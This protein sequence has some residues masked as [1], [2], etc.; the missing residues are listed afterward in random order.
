M[1]YN[2]IRFLN[3]KLIHSHAV[4]VIDDLSH[5]FSYRPSL[6]FISSYIKEHQNYG[7]LLTVYDCLE[8]LGFKVSAYICEFDQIKNLN[9]IFIAQLKSNNAPFFSIIQDEGGS[10]IYKTSEGKR[11]IASN[12]DFQEIWTGN[13][14]DVESLEVPQKSRSLDLKLASR[15]KTTTSILAVSLLIYLIIKNLLSIE[16]NRGFPMLLLLLMLL[17]IFGLTIASLLLWNEIDNRSNIVQSI[18]SAFGKSGCNAVTDSLIAK[19]FEKI[20]SFNEIGFI[21]FLGTFVYLLLDVNNGSNLKFLSYLSCSSSFFI[22]FSFLYQRFV[23]KNWCVLCVLIQITLLSEIIVFLS[24]GGTNILQYPIN[25]YN[26]VKLAFIFT[27]LAA[28]IKLIKPHLI[29]SKSLISV[30]RRLNKIK[31]D[32]NTFSSLMSTSRQ[33]QKPDEHLGI[34]K[35]SKSKIELIKVCS[36]YCSPCSKVHP[37]LDELVKNNLVNL[38]VIF[39]A[40]PDDTTAE[41]QVVAH[42]MAIY[43]HNNE[44][45][46]EAMDLWYMTKDYKL[47]ANKFP[48]E[49]EIIKK[50]KNKVVDMREWCTK[51]EITH[52]PTLFLNNF[53]LP[54]IY[55]A[56]DLQVLL[57]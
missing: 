43:A 40:K 35:K 42:L 13:V 10:Y 37:I 50:Q 12:K 26:V 5:H 16:E 20:L 27:A 2:P 6:S 9:N 45:I 11:I 46:N 21:Y 8:E 22:A 57:S 53:L 49:D 24:F 1:S 36:P 52:T 48:I 30:K 17:K 7:S 3:K 31:Y 44:Q 56:S 29:Q 54:K 34:L 19:K 4:N 23:I 15:I 55:E 28:L 47:F 33:V 32:R 39:T 41:F 38:R 51:N 25:I 18:C 14:I